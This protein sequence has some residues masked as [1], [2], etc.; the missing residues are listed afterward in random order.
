MPRKRKRRR[1]SAGLGRLLG[2]LSVML[3]VVV[4]VAAL[5]MFF[6]VGEID[7]SGNSRYTG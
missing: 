6:K 7:V 1:R 2:P 3:A 5:T 4:V